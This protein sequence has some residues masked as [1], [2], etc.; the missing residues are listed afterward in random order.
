LADEQKKKVNI[1][2]FIYTEGRC[3]RRDAVA[4]REEHSADEQKRRVIIT[5]FICTDGRCLRRR[6]AAAAVKTLSADEQEKRI[7]GDVPS[8]H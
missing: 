1:T 8:K 6:D 2:S 3:L 5:S 4:T 7:R